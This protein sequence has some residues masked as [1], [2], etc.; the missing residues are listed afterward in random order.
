M[1]NK[2]CTCTQATVK[3]SKLY[4]IPSTR[5]ISNNTRDQHRGTL[6]QIYKLHSSCFLK[7]DHRLLLRDDAGFCIGTFDSEFLALILILILLLLMLCA[8]AYQKTHNTT[9][10][11]HYA[12]ERETH[13]CV[14]VQRQFDNLRLSV[15]IR[16][17][18]ERK[19]YC[20]QNLSVLFSFH[21]TTAK[22]PDITVFDGWPTV[23]KFKAFLNTNPS[24]ITSANETRKHI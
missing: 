18:A 19:S 3:Q 20:L 16:S 21:S 22:E 23:E 9:F 2:R 5:N 4:Q 7:H 1:T 6:P 14:L 11:Y 13:R 24:I 8:V 12:V 10:T 17:Q 15:G